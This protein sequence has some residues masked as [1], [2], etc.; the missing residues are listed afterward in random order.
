MEAKVVKS[1]DLP[2]RVALT[3]FE[4][5]NANAVKVTNKYRGVH[6]LSITTD[7]E[8]KDL[9]YPEGWYYAK[10]CFRNKH[11]STTGIYSEV[12]MFKSDG[13]P[14]RKVAKYQTRR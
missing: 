10:G 12:E 13:T 9:T 3:V 8:P 1:C 2:V 6:L 14:W 4:L 5:L 7:T 11:E